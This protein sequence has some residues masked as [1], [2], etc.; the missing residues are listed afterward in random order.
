MRPWKRNL[1]NDVDLFWC[2]MDCLNDG[3]E[4][5]KVLQVFSNRVY[6]KSSKL[7]VS[8]KRE[9]FSNGRAYK[10]KYRDSFCLVCGSSQVIRHHIVPLSNGGGNVTSNL[11]PI[12]STCHAK[13]HPW[14]SSGNNL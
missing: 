2:L 12:C 10:V 9:K 4:R 14:M 3:Q 7:Y 6:K 1:L 11:S 13:I 5:L 8:S